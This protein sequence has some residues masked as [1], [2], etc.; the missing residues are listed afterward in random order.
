[1]ILAAT[2]VYGGHYGVDLLGGAA[3]MAGAILLWRRLGPVLLSGR[4]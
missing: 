4:V 2:P 1:M 3:V